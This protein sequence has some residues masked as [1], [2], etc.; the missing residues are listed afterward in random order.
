MVLLYVE[1]SV[2]SNSKEG[3]FCLYWR[4]PNHKE[5]QLDP[6]VNLS[7]SLGPFKSFHMLRYK[8]SLYTGRSRLDQTGLYIS[9]LA[10]P[11]TK[12]N[13]AAEPHQP[14]RN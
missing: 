12:L 8:F 10:V 11:N 6:K 1:L 7:Q 2:Y 13:S 14:G 5:I 3:S 4:S 9:V